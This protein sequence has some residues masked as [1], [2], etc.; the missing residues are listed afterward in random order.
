MKEW[1]CI[2]RFT[3]PVLNNAVSDVIFAIFSDTISLGKLESRETEREK[4]RERKMPDPTSITSIPFCL[5]L[6]TNLS[7]ISFSSFSFRGHRESKTGKEYWRRWEKVG[8]RERWIVSSS[9]L[10][11][12]RLEMRFD[13]GDFFFCKS[14]YRGALEKLS[15]VICIKRSRRF[16]DVISF[17]VIKCRDASARMC[18]QNM[19][20]SEPSF[21]F[22]VLWAD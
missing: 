12:R 18:I 20:T 5:L 2:Y 16:R 3:M 21:Q 14:L 17:N 6:I 7:S 22:Q 1:P 13:S 15:T 8:E 10:T 4:E 19:Q 11:N 9:F